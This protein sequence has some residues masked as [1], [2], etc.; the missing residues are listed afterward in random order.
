MSAKRLLTHPILISL[1]LVWLVWQGSVTLF[2]VNP[3]YLPPIAAV[4]Q[5]IQQNAS[6]LLSSVWRT[7]LETVL[8]FSLGTLFG[9]GCGILFFY[10]AWLDRAW[11]PLFIVS[12]T[13]P[14]VAFGALVVIWFGNTMLSKVMIAFYLTFLP[15]TLNSKRGLQSV[16]A[17]HINLL[18]SFGASGFRRFLSL[19]FPAAAPSIFVAMKLGISLGLV[20][21][22]VGEWFGDTEGLGVL[23]IQ[24]MYNEDVV[25]MW[26]LIVIC[27]ALGATL[28]GLIELLER[29]FAW[30]GKHP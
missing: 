23:L 11:F 25:R 26:S 28:Y 19:H 17:L 16:D 6:L 4:A 20:G 12:Q 7:G 5:D 14:V 9:L 21:A 29:K 22:I 15:V 3:R 24:A 13:V 27:G 8:G 30:W 1:L 10:V 18:R 2:T